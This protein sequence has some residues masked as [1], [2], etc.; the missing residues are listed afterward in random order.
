MDPFATVAKLR[1][2]H[3]THACE[4]PA[5][6][7]SANAS[8]NTDCY[9]LILS[10][11]LLLLLLLLLCLYFNFLLAV[12]LLL[13]IISIIRTSLTSITVTS[14]VVIVSFIGTSMPPL[15]SLLLSL[16]FFFSMM[17][18]HC[19]CF[20]SAAS[21]VRAHVMPEVFLLDPEPRSRI[22]QNRL[23]GLKGPVIDFIW[24]QYRITK[25]DSTVPR[26][27]LQTFC[28]EETRRGRTHVRQLLRKAT[29][30][31]PEGTVRLPIWN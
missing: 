8:S 24:V 10:Y 5:S 1:S 11:L 25:P 29:C 18:Y 20:L 31:N 15:F 23:F 4:G 3:R 30:P 22:Y 12:L 13:L 19:Y 16:F 21:C 9:T 26:T 7:L 2:S 14:I 28:G 6:A 17:Q 27:T